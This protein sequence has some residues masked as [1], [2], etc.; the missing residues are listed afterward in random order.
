MTI[1]QG[2]SSKKFTG[3]KRR[4]S[5]L[6]K[7]HELGR[8]PTH[9][10]IGEDARKQI[11]GMGGSTKTVVLRGDS[12]NVYVPAEKKTVRS[13]IITVKENPANPHY[14]QRNI[15]NKSTVIQT[16]LGMARITSRPGRDGTINAVLL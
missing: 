12:V 15:M 1:F 2:K 13:K 7:R 3:G 6:K 10:R 5:R 16:E 4:H 11:R 14:V 8:E 9:T